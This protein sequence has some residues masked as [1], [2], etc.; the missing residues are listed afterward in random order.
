MATVT[1]ISAISIIRVL[2]I[3]RVGQGP[4]SVPGVKAGDAVVIFSKDNRTVNPFAVTFEHFITVDDE[5]QQFNVGDLT[6]D[7]FD[8]LLLR[9]A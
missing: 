5:I 2:L 8:L 4:I 6:T 1:L 3:G 9:G 7:T